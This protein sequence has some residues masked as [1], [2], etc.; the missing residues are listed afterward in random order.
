[1]NFLPVKIPEIFKTV[2]P[3]R[4]WYIDTDEKVIYLTFDD[5]PTLVITDWVL[6]CLKKFKAQATFFC[7]GKNVEAHPRIYQRILKE[8]HAVGNHTFNH[9]NGWKTNNSTYLNDINLA[10]Q[11]IDSSLFRPPYG[12]INREQSKLILGADFKIIMWTVLSKD[13]NR[14]VLPQECL[15]NV[16]KNVDRGSIIVFH[17]SEKAFKNMQYTLPR[18]LD[19]YSAKGFNF[20]RIPESIL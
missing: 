13:Y 10:E 12:R 2:F 18:F 15:K 4:T 1:M 9:M 16:I 5:G 3:N 6:D 7:I 17:D 11:H 8:K 19:I 14:K 20:K